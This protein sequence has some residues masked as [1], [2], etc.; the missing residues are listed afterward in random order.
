[1]TVL[2]QRAGTYHLSLTPFDPILFHSVSNDHRY[3]TL[4][5]MCAYILIEL[6]VEGVLKQQCQEVTQF[7]KNERNSAIEVDE[8]VPGLHFVRSWFNPTFIGQSRRNLHDLLRVI[9][10][11]DMQVSR[12]LDSARTKPWDQLLMVGLDRAPERNGVDGNE[13]YT[14]DAVFESSAICYSMKGQGSSCAV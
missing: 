8:F 7:F 5:E 2:W 12:L 1:M 6:K 3:D 10:S 11:I 13:P 4:V 14:R 9:E